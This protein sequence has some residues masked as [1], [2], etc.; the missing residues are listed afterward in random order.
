MAC[1]CLP[2]SLLRSRPGPIPATAGADARQPRHGALLLARARLQLPHAAVR[3][4]DLLLW[5]G[6]CSSSRCC[7]GTVCNP[8]PASQ[9]SQHQS[10]TIAPRHR[11]C[12]LQEVG[13]DV[14]FDRRL[15]FSG[16]PSNL[17][18]T[19][20][21][22]CDFKKGDEAR[23]LRSLTDP[24]VTV[25]S[26]PVPYDD[27]ATQCRL[28]AATSLSRSVGACCRSCVRARRLPLTGDERVSL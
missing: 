14:L 1:S 12:I 21:G 27:V 26:S 16:T 3:R 25:Q 23:I 15:G 18:P 8:A 13:G 28:G 5:A 24:E 17:L 6:Q 9:P 20:L 11:S 10:R 22:T 7:V 4:E 2:R 19:S